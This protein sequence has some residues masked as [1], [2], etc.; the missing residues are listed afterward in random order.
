MDIHT[1][2]AI[3]TAS[4]SGDPEVYLRTP[5][6]ESFNKL[7]LMY[8]NSFTL[9][10]FTGNTKGLSQVYNEAIDQIS[11]KAEGL[12]DYVVFVHD[13][14]KIQDLF[15]AEKLS[16]AHEKLGFDVVGLAGTRDLDFKRSNVYAWHTLAAPISYSGC[17]GHFTNPEKTKISYTSFGPMPSRVITVDGLFIL[18]RTTT[19]LSKN[20]RFDENFT[21]DFYDMAFCLRAHFAGMKIGVTD[22]SVVHGSVGN[23][24]AAP[25]Y[26]EA[27]KLFKIQYFP[28][29]GLQSEQAH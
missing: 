23:G 9:Y 18:C 24:I 3:V 2:I 6:I 14:V 20:V 27:Q 12:P 22:I 28:Q 15:F 25:K 21:F 4:A 13:D 26:A 7:K 16:E 11:L 29:L 17:V 8:G 10:H 5:I 1:R 19:L